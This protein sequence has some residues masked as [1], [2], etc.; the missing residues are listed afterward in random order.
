MPVLRWIEFIISVLSSVVLPRLPISSRHWLWVQA[1][2]GDSY[3]VCLVLKLRN[4]KAQ[5]IECELL[6]FLYS[7]PF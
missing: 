5:F 7:R 6:G 1:A 3:T 4:P 2:R